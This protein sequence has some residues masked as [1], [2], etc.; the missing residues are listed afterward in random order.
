MCKPCEVF[1]DS[2]HG[3]TH[4]CKTTQLHSGTYW[5]LQEIYLKLRL[6]YYTMEKPLRNAK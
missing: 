6:D 4:K 2:K 5:V 1:G 3:P